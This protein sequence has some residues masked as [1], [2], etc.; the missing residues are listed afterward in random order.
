MKKEVLNIIIILSV[1][2]A[3]WGCSATKYVPKDSYLLNEVKIH[4]DNKKV[5]SSDLRPYLRQTPNAKWFSLFKTPL[6]I[7]N[8]SGRDSTKW[9]NRFLRKIGDEPVIFSE[10]EADRT[11]EELVKAIQNMGYMR[12]EVSRQKKTKRKLAT[13]HYYIK[14]GKPYTVENIKYDINDEL[15]THYMK[16]DSANS[17]LHNDMQF[18]VNV[19]NA[20]RDRI[21]QLLQNNG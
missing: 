8:L 11:Q 7:Y 18:D 20:E 19:L 21:T 9:M 1:I 13:V 6:Y 10:L 5:K 16:K 15:M 4:S 17:L 14:T 2:L 3:F 12:V